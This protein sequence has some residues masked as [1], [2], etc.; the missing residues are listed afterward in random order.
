MKGKL[1]SN[2]IITTK[3][4]KGLRSGFSLVEVL[5]AL[6]I[7]AVGLLGVMATLVWATRNA[8]S[9]K[10]VT[11]ATSLAR[12]LTETVRMRGVQHPLPSGSEY[13]TGPRKK[14]LDPP[15]NSLENEVYLA[16]VKGQA[17]AGGE[18][19][20]QSGLDR[21]ERSII[22]REVDT[23]GSSDP[24]LGKIGQLT[25][26]VFWKEK[27]RERHVAIETIIPLSL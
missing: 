20:T 11:E 22:V 8:D 21:F 5:V 9:G 24:H 7:I 17:G 27:Q 1:E 26:K 15:F 19:N 2:V 16:P 18:A 3:Y 25:V 12:T 23:G 6:F 13:V 4:R 14:V 10:V